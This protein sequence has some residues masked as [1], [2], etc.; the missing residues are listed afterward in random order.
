MNELPSITPIELKQELDGPNPPKLLD[1]RDPE[2]LEI[3]RLNIDYHIPMEAFG[4]RY[5]ELDP[6]EQIVVICRSGR[7]SAQVVEFLTGQGFEHVRN[8]EGG[9]NGWATQVDPSVTIY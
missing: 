1:V 6:Q 4:A 5:G 8:L 3:S 2:E 9:M 7:R